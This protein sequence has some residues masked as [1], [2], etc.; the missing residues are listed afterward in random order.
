MGTPITAPKEKSEKEKTP[1]DV[2][3]LNT[4]CNYYSEIQL[5]E[6]GHSFVA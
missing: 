1:S 4:K 2:T 3:I 6:D 5:Q